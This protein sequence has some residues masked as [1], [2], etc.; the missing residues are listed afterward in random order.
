MALLEVKHWFYPCLTAPLPVG[1]PLSQPIK[2]RGYLQGKGIE[3]RELLGN[4]TPSDGHEPIRKNRRRRSAD[5]DP[6]AGALLS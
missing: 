2:G 3:I 6:E 4:Q 1:R 5:E